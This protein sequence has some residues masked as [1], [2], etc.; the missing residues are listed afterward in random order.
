MTAVPELIEQGIE[1]G[2]LST[3]WHRRA[4]LKRCVL[5]EF[6]I[7]QHQRCG[8][9]CFIAIIAGDVGTAPARGKC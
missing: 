1:L 8:E 6:E 4:A 7:L 9:P 5:R 3:K 2:C